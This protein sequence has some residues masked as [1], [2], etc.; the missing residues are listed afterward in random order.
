MQ[1]TFILTFRRN[2]VKTSRA[3]AALLAL[4]L[5]I[6]AA[7]AEGLDDRTAAGFMNGLNQVQMGARPA[8]ANCP[9]LGQMSWRMRSGSQE[10][11]S[12]YRKLYSKQEVNI[13]VAFGYYDSLPDNKNFTAADAADFSE[14]LTQF[15][16]PVTSIESGQIKISAVSQRDPDDATLFYKQVTDSY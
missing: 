15:C 5:M 11:L 13:S 2:A 6:R 14:K 12:N 10:C 1:K 9:T 8:P 4:L 16:A 7:F 3:A